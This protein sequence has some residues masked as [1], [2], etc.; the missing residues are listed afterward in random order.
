[1]DSLWVEMDHIEKGIALCII[2][3]HPL[4][5]PMAILKMTGG[6]QCCLLR[7]K[8][9]DLLGSVTEEHTSTKRKVLP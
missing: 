9:C 2:V 1:M 5:N 3:S 6:K 7:F 4:P 8:A